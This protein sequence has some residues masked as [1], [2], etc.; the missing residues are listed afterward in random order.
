MVLC[1]TLTGWFKLNESGKWS[2]D[3]GLKEVFSR[4]FHS[5]VQMKSRVDFKVKPKTFNFKTLDSTSALKLVMVNQPKKVTAP[6]PLIQGRVPNIRPANN[7]P[8]AKTRIQSRLCKI[9]ADCD[10]ATT[11]AKKFNKLSVMKTAQR[12]MIAWLQ[13]VSGQMGT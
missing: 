13:S 11:Q 5:K 6:G 7:K 9:T 8:S 12:K 4:I 2:D 1:C 3:L 10:V